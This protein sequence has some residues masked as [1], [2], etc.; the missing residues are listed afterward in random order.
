MRKTT[1]SFDHLSL[2]VCTGSPRRGGSCKAKKRLQWK[3][4]KEEGR[5]SPI[6]IKERLNVVGLY[7]KNIE[8]RSSPLWREELH[9]L[10]K[11]LNKNNL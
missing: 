5:E 10:T 1:T 3:G 4:I 7:V 9:Y 11:N 6:K 8:I 2:S